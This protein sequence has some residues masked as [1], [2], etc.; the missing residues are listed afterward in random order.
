VSVPA[1]TAN[2]SD[3]TLAKIKAVLALDGITGQ[4]GEVVINLNNQSSTAKLF[5]NASVE[6]GGNYGVNVS[7]EDTFFMSMRPDGS[8]LVHV[9]PPTGT[10][11]RFTI[12]KVTGFEYQLGPRETNY[13]FIEHGPSGN[14]TKLKARIRWSA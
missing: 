1:A 5:Q 8:L 9:G 12:T 6:V 7:T 11:A 2:P 13:T 14:E 3:P 10:M 4:A